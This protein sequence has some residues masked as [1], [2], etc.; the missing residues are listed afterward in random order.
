[1]LPSTVQKVLFFHLQVGVL[2]ATVVSILAQLHVKGPIYVRG[3]T[4]RKKG[5]RE[6]IENKI[7]YL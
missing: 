6:G 2:L 3:I 1:M 5:T 7:V 4:R